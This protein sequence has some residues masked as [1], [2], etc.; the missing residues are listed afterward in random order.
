[1]IGPTREV[2][3]PSPAATAPRVSLDA[4]FIGF[5]GIGRMVDGLWRGLIEI[6]A[7]VTALWPGGPAGDWMGD[8]RPAPAGPHVSVRARPFLPAEQL[9]LP[10]A[11]R[12]LGAAVHHAPYFAVPYL[13]RLPIVLTVHDL[14]PYLDA[15][16]ARSPAAAAVYRTIVPL[17]IRKARIVAAVSP[18]AARQVSESLGLAQERLRVVEHGVDRTRWRG[19]GEEQIAAVRER[20]RL[21]ADYLLYVGTLKRHKNVQ[22][23]LEAHRPE[24]PPLVFAGPGA[25]ELAEAELRP[26]Q[27]RNVIALGRVSDETL[28]ALYSGALAL[29]LPSLYEAVGFTALEAMA[30]GTPVVS[31]DGGGLPDTIG[32]GGL[33]VPA[34]DVGAWSEALSAISEQ[35]ALRERLA[36]A[37]EAIVAQRS[38]AQAARSYLAIYREAA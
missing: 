11:L 14:F 1:M 2:D 18:F 23:L 13:S 20:H 36:A 15:A 34:L 28:R 12:R 16:N 17:A 38:W 5:A 22:T 32:A 3:V 35:P 26:E 25:A 24:H 6:G 7:D 4:R 19:A 37:G 33:L 31:S 30:C 9:I 29:V 27:M 8:H 10:I 21:P